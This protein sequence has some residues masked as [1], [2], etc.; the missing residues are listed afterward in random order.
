MGANAEAIAAVRE[1]L[2]GAE[3][4][5]ERFCE[6]ELHRAHAA[7]LLA[8]DRSVLADAER[9]LQRALEAARARQARMSELRVAADLARLWAESG[10]RGEAY[11][12]LA[13]VHA[14]FTEGLD[15]PDLQQAKALLDALARSSPN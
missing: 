1:G 15:T 4:T 11:D 12:L 10:R 8:H 7:A 2:A 14:W 9:A 3:A 6:A 5:E 13:P